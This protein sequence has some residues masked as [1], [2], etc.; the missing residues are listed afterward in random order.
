[1]KFAMQRTCF[2]ALAKDIRCR[3]SEVFAD[4]LVEA[5]FSGGDEAWPH[6][7]IE[8]FAVD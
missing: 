8:V 1:L 4:A 2:I 5:G 3:S 6:A 7:G